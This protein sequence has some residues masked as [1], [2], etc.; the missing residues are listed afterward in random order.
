MVRVGGEGGGGSEGEAEVE[1]CS[2][3]EGADTRLE[4]A[5]MWRAILNHTKLCCTTGTTQHNRKVHFIAGAAAAE[6]R[7][8]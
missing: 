8:I 1:G 5:A 4:S 6:K 7:S 2:E 3:D